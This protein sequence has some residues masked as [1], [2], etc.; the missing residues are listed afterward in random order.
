MLHPSTVPGTQVRCPD[1][2]RPR[3]GSTWLSVLVVLAGACT[4]TPAVPRETPPTPPEPADAATV[5][6]EPTPPPV[7]DVDVAE[8]EA[9]PRPFVSSLEPGPDAVVAGAPVAERAGD[10]A[11]L[12]AAPQEG[13][14]R[15]NER[16]PDP[17]ADVRETMLGGLIVATVYDRSD[18]VA[19]PVP[20]TCWLLTRRSTREHSLETIR[21]SLAELDFAVDTD[22]RALVA[23]SLFFECGH[24]RALWEGASALG[25]E[26]PVAAAAEGRI[27]SARIAREGEEYRVTVDAL[28]YSHKTWGMAGPTCATLRRHL[29]RIGPS[30]YDVE[31][32]DLWDCETDGAPR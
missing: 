4:T 20:T 12:L 9:L 22:N 1:A 6:V 30:T 3:G 10:S 28:C 29:F 23:S 13:R 26:G 14:F 7:A 32:E 31:E 2:A 16:Y 15:D 21:E 5:P 18:L 24:C 27:G 8:P 19:D 25:A 11:R 17:R